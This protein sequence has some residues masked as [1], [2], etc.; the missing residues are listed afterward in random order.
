MCKLA[1][2]VAAH[3]PRPPCRAECYVRHH[4]RRARAVQL[5]VRRHVQAC[6]CRCR[7]R[8]RRARPRPPRGA[9]F[10][11]RHHGRRIRAVQLCIVSCEASGGV[12]TDRKRWRT[13]PGCC[14]KRSMSFVVLTGEAVAC[15][16]CVDSWER[17]GGAVSMSGGTQHRTLSEVPSDEAVLSMLIEEVTWFIGDV[18]DHGR[19]CVTPFP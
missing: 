15:M 12:G 4:G 11:V 13:L 16:C 19:C 5:R 7:A 6:W 8:P 9:E 14:T 1:G 3:S 17:L 10:Y 2:A 18:R